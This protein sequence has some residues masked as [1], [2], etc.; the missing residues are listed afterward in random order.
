MEEHEAGERSQDVMLGCGVNGVLM[1]FGF[2][3]VG[4]QFLAE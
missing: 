1:G 3:K 2:I 4:W